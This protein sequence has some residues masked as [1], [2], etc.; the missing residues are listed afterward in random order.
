MIER[1]RLLTSR[2]PHNVLQHGS[3]SAARD[4]KVL[5]SKAHKMLS[6]NINYISD[7]KLA[8]VLRRLEQFE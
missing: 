5:A 6:G 2:V 3:V 7:S 1:L 4:W 8:D